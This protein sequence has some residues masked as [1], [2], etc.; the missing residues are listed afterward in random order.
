MSTDAASTAAA[1]AP[2]EKF[3]KDYHPVPFAVDSVDL[4]FDLRDGA[5]AAERA[6]VVTA[7][8]QITK[9][10]G[11]SGDMELD[12]EDIEVKSVEID[13]AAVTG[14]TVVEDVLRI[15]GS[16]IPEGTSFTLQTVSAISP[17]A[18]TQL[19]GLYKSSGMFCTQCEAE[20]FRR[21][22]P[23][24]DRPDVMTTYRVY[25]EADK[26]A[27]PVLLSN[28][29]KVES[30]PVPDDASRHFA[31]WED[32]FRKPSYLFAVVA[33]DLGSVQDD[34]TTASGRKVALEVFSEHANVDQLTHA[35][36]SLKR[37]MT[38]D[39]ERYGLEY[40][41]DMYNIVA[42]NDFNMG[43]MENK[44]LNIFNTA[45][46]LAKPETATDADYERIESVIGHE[47][48]H[49]WSG[50]RVT[51]RDWFQLTLKEG[52]TVYRDQ[53]FSADMGSAAVCRVNDVRSLRARQFPEDGGPMAHPIRPESYIAMDNFYTS[54][55]YEKGAEVIRMYEALV[56]RDGFRKGLDLYFS[57][58]DGSAV[59]CDDFRAAMADANG[60]D[61]TQ[62]ERW[63]TQ[64]GTPRVKA[65]GNYD[66]DAGVYHLTLTQSC[67][68]TPGQET[69]EP[70]HIPVAVGLLDATTGAE[71]LPTVTLELTELEQTFDLSIASTDPAPPAAVVP[72]ILRGFSAPVKLELDPPLGDDQLAFLMAHDT[73]AFNRWEASQKLTARV[74][75]DAAA[76]A[77]ATTT[78]T[79]EVADF[80][81]LPSAV[82]DAFRA[83][84]AAE[85][86]DRSL[87][88]YALALPSLSELADLA[89][90]PVDP[91]ALVAARKHVK[92]SIATALQAELADT[93]D[94]LASSEAY[95]V[96]GPEIGRR[97]LRNLCLDY[98]SS[99]EPD[100]N[101]AFAQFTSAN[102]MTDKLAALSCLTGKSDGAGADRRAQA[103]E[104]FYKDA[105]GDAL[106]VNKWFSTQ[107]SADLPDALDRVRALLEHPDFTWTN[108][109]RMRS[110][111]SIFAGANMAAFHAAD[112][113][114][115]EFVGDAVV[116]VDKIN[117]QIA[118]RL[119]GAFSLWRRYDPARQEM[120]TAQLKRIKDTPDVSKDV[121]EIVSRSLA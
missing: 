11:P 56:G 81:P 87:Q 7:L 111:V 17:A 34:F 13:G 66:A 37:A 39:E 45:L 8:L 112:G 96:E 83:T 108:P 44:G 12:C 21:I 75:L 114:G 69:K 78:A 76:T 72:S 115:Y 64:A 53:E 18:N 61:L 90:P 119:A 101:R 107:A 33:G 40:D 28:G 65:Q 116:K 22:T 6:T 58:H 99:I 70:F 68:T 80:S 77:A 29:N 55:V 97:A 106:V 25:I 62:F 91:L 19:S 109:N 42:V 48:F 31:V 57:R 95:S 63:Y 26:A 102:C 20:G 4:R 120:M 89:P 121:F 94:A 5:D 73:D 67:P 113:S 43:A 93:Y 27:Y 1:P 30:G 100:G 2:V 82:I 54:T 60:V 41:L 118:A 24:F 16:S 35:M 110:V 46:T 10:A 51:C 14:F 84:L 3:R 36:R 71:V 52:L 117:N 86:L 15:P 85:G 103:L 79:G 105:A 47:Y 104:E 92:Q 38:W 74:V 88:A 49:N 59:A 32:P 50:N 98:L 9:D 23:F